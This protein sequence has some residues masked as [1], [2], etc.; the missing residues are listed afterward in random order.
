MQQMLPRVDEQRSSCS[1]IVRRLH[2]RLIGASGRDMRFM[3]SFIIIDYSFIRKVH[4][5]IY[6]YIQ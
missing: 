2:C 5:N 4:N 6:I 1:D 3:R